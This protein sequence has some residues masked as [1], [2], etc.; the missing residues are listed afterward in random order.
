MTASTSAFHQDDALVIRRTQDCTPIAEHTTRL[1]NEGAT[2][3]SE[4]RHAASFPAV[5]VEKY[6]ND[7][8]ITF[9]EFLRDETHV[10]RM[11]QDPALSAFRVW[12]GQV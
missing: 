1:R 2:G 12:E 9:T 10:K 7:A 3:S 4:M 8:G 6:I 11:L 5:L